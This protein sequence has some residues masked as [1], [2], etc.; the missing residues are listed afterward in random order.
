MR[1]KDLPKDID[2][3]ILIKSE[4]EKKSI[5]IVDSLAKITDKFPWKTQINILTERSFIDGNTLAK[6]IIIEGKSIKES[7]SYANRVGF[8]PKTLF[9]YSLKNFS[10]SKRVQFHYALHGRNKTGGILKECEGTIFMPGAILVPIETEEI[11]KQ[12][13]LLW[14]ISYKTHH[15]LFS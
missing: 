6:T 11:M 2:L 3:C 9:L 15:L 10:K 8:Q 4:D 7:K 14:D 12:V 5:D 1:G 13:F